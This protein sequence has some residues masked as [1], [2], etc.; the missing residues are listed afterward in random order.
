MSRNRLVERLR[1]ATLVDSAS[2]THAV[3][4]PNDPPLTAHTSHVVTLLVGL[5]LIM[6]GHV[7]HHCTGED[8]NVVLAG[9]DVYAI[10][11]TE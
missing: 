8:Q 6:H 5:V 4:L 11:I 9:S 2:V 3:H 10:C 7:D 1:Y